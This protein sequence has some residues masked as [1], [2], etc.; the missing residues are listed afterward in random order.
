MF[1]PFERKLKVV[2]FLIAAI[3]AGVVYDKNSDIEFYENLDFF[4][5]EETFKYQL[6]DKVNIYGDCTET[7][8][9][10]SNEKDVVKRELTAIIC[11]RE[12]LTD[13]IKNGA[14]EIISK[15]AYNFSLIIFNP[16]RP[17]KMLAMGYKL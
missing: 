10:C 3:N 9:D 15:S 14:C 11:S 13:I 7:E 16:F 5:G 1:H 6:K 12:F 8:T 4:N 17:V 2:A